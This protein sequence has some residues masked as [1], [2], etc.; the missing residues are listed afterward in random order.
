[1]K[2]IKSKWSREVPSYGAFDDYV[3]IASK[4]GNERILM[5]PEE[6]EYI[7]TQ[8]YENWLLKKSKYIQLLKEWNEC[9][10]F[11]GLDEHPSTLKD[12]EDTIAAIKLVQG[13]ETLMY[14]DMTNED[15][16]LLLAFLVRNKRN[17]LKIW[18]E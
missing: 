7:T 11:N 10:G 1:M 13:T 2:E 14:G 5:R 17:E 12:N 4:A 15:L 9:I 6:F 16:E 3:I 8:L 18:K